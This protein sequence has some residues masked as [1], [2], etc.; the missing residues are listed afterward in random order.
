LPLLRLVWLRA[1]QNKQSRIKLPFT[2][3][4]VRIFEQQSAKVNRWFDVPGCKLSRPVRANVKAREL[5]LRK[6]L[7]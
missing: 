4:F 7:L 5:Q 3:T 1:A 6:R 2:L